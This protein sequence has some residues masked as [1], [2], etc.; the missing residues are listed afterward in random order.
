MRLPK[1]E[2]INLEAHHRVRPQEIEAGKRKRGR[3]G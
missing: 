2:E 3:S 1:G